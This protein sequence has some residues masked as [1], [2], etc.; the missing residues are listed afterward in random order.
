MKSAPPN[1]TVLPNASSGNLALDPKQREQEAGNEVGQREAADEQTGANAG[2]CGGHQRRHLVPRR[3]AG[4]G[5]RH[6]AEEG[7]DRS[8]NLFRPP[9]LES[10]LVHNL[11][12]SIRG[13]ADLARCV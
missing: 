1:A 2:D 5:E 4:C 8:A 12:Q 9:L 13:H 11:Q 7:K 3:R 10:A 6:Q